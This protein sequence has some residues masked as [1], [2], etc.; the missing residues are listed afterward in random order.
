MILL[1]TNLPGKQGVLEKLKPH[2]EELGFRTDKHTSNHSGYFSGLL[3]SQGGREV[4]LHLPFLIIQAKDK[5][6]FNQIQFK[7]PLLINQAGS[8]VSPPFQNSGKH[9][10][11][12]IQA[13]EQAVQ[14]VINHIDNNL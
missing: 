5:Q 14:Q 4:Y 12:W 13:G 11:Y 8:S 3:S 10:K 9:S 6:T 1:H 7:T 2:L